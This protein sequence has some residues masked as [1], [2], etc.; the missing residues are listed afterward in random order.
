MVGKLDEAIKTGVEEKDIETS[1]P[2]VK[3][4]RKIKKL[5]KIVDV[6][7]VSIDIG[8]KYI[9]IL[10]AKKKKDTIQ[11][12]SALKI[13]SPADIVEKGEL[14]NLPS[15]INALKMAF[16]KWHVSAKDISFTSIAGSVMSREVTIA[17]T[18]EITIAERQMLVE[19]ELRQYLPIN[20]ADYQIQFTDAGKV[21]VDGV[22]KQKVLVIVYPIKLIKNFLGIISETGAKLRPCSLDVTNNSL[23]KFFNHV[24]TINGQPIDRKKV[25]LFIDMGRNTFNT[26]IIADGKLQFM[27]SIEASQDEIDRS[28]GLRIGKHYDEAEVLK[29]EQC[30]LMATEL[31]DEQVE[32]NDVTK[33]YINRWI[34]DITRITQFYGNK[35]Q[36]RVE[37]VY[38]YGG[39]A[40]LKGLAPYMQERLDIETEKINEFDGLDL[41]KNVNVA[42]IDQFIN[43]IGTVIRF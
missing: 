13:E 37:K 32:I 22:M 42:N 2:V 16:M 14:R 43:A 15:I 28:I 33:G 40:K 25:H 8:S 3:K 1:K 5:P 30:D 41:G 19:S 27:R 17:D 18:D 24:K 38:I 39:G 21:E 10:E 11:I 35:E 36:Q 6:K 12:I 29:T 20:L 31:T 23:Q 9:K 4:K 7:M 34:D 26:S